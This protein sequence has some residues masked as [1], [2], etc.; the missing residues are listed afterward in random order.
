M[1]V[2]IMDGGMGGEIALRLDGAGHGLWS[3]KALLEA[4]EVV[5]DIHREYIAAGAE[6]IIT[7]TYATIPHY[8]SK[9]GL[10]D[11]YIE[12]TRL[13]GEL[14]QR[15]VR[16]SG[17]EVQVAGS[18]P[19][20]NESYRADLV[21]APEQAMPVYR[22][23]VEALAP[24]VDLY[25]CETMSCAQEALNAASQA[26]AFGGGRPVYVCWTLDE[27]PGRGLRS[28][29]NIQQALDA[30][31]DLDLAGYMFNCTSP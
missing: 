29:E 13:A 12:L 11:R 21:P 16:E 14:A 19:P 15:A 6:I 20:L 26:L 10:E 28:G 4:P 5:V 24:N 22:N 9:A 7:N 17:C 2:T 31:A 18:L 23:M 3:A 8:L 30:L 27:V 1:G 25:V